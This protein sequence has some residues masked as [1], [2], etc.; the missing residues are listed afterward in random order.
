MDFGTVPGTQCLKA[1][2]IPSIT[3]TIMLE[4]QELWCWCP[5]KVML[6]PESPMTLGGG[7]LQSHQVLRVDTA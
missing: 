6:K 4:I 2:H 1:L 5:P 3:T 7:A